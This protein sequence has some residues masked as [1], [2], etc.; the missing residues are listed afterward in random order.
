MNIEKNLGSLELSL[1]RVEL[2][3]SEC[4]QGWIFEVLIKKLER[5]G[6]V[7]TSHII[8][9]CPDLVTIVPYRRT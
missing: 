3:V 8:C 6:I 5:C 2:H 4:L 7:V 9:Q 1:I